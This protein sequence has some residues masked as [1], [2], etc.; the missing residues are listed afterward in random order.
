MKKSPLAVM[1]AGTFL[2]ENQRHGTL[3][4]T[5]RWRN[6]RVTERHHRHGGPQNGPGQF[7]PDPFGQYSGDNRSVKA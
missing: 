7:V 5:F 4:T 6:K 3:P 1:L 2:G